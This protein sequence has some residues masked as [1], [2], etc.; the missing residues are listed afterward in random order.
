MAH[1]SHAILAS[2]DTETEGFLKIAPAYDAKV[3]LRLVSNASLATDLI[4]QELPRCFGV[5][6][7][8]QHRRK[9]ISAALHEDIRK[10]FARWQEA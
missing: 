10:S 5:T 4:V 2:H 1:P 7:D 3:A 9:A 6:E 8:W